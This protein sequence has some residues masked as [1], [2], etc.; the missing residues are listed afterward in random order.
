M[1]LHTAFCRVNSHKQNVGAYVSLFSSYIC[2]LVD[3]EQFVGSVCCAVIENLAVSVKTG[4][5]VS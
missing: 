2:N 3:P 5:L 4:I 1:Q